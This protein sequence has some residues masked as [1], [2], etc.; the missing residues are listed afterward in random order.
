MSAL[1]RSMNLK[2][3][4]AKP[5]NSLFVPGCPSQTLFQR[6]VT[7]LGTMPGI[8]SEFRKLDQ[9]IWLPVKLAI[10]ITAPTALAALGMAIAVIGRQ[11]P[12]AATLLL[13]TH[14]FVIILGYTM[15]PCSSAE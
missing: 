2:R 5:Q 3:T 11:G 4:C 7:E 12:S 9:S 6:A 8:S 10:G 15:T 1:K 14:V 13:A